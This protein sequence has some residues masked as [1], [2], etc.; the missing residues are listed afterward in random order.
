LL[1]FTVERLSVFHVVC[2]RAL[3]CLPLA[4]GDVLVLANALRCPFRVIA[5]YEFRFP[6]FHC[7]ALLGL[8]TPRGAM[9]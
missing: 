7:L 9:K 6:V 5:V 1:A 2:V 3:S 8:A 4:V